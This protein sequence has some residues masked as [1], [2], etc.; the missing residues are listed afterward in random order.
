MARAHVPL[1]HRLLTGVVALSLSSPALV[2]LPGTALTSVTLLPSD[3]ARTSESVPAGNYGNDIALRVRSAAG[4]S[5]RSY[6]KFSVTGLSGS[7]ASA[8]L[9][10]YVTDATPDGGRVYPTAT[11]WSESSITWSSAPAISGPSLGAVGPAALSA[12][13][14][15]DVTSTI[16]GNGAYSF[17]VSDGA[18]NSVLFSSSEGANPPQLVITDGGVPAPP[19]SDFIASPTSGAAPLP[20][21]FTDASTGQPTSWAWDFDGDGITDSTLQHPQHLYQAPG[22]YSV[23]LTVQNDLGTDTATKDELISVNSAT[24]IVGAGDIARCNAGGDEQ[25][26]ALLGGI[27]GTVITLGDNAYE[28][29]SAAEYANCYDPTWGTQKGRT[30]PAPGNHEYQTPGATGYFGYFGATAGDPSRGYYGYDLGSWHVIVLNSE[31]AYIGGCGAG[32]PEEQWLRADLAEHASANV[33]AI[34][35]KPRFSSGT[36]H[37]SDP[38]MGPF[39]NALYEYGADIILNGHEHNYERFAPQS[40]FGVSDATYGIRELVSGTGGASHY[41]FGSPI[42]NSE[43]RNNTTFGVLKLT[44]DAASYSW[45]FVPVGGGS[46]TDSGTTTTHGPPPPSHTVTVAPTDDAYV[47]EAAPTTNYSSDTTLRLR[48]RRGVSAHSYLSF[49]VSGVTAAPTSARLRLYCTDGSP[50]GGS[51]YLVGGPWSESTITWANAPPIAGTRLGAFGPATVGT[52]VELDLTST[53][54]GDGTYT[55]GITTTTNN[56]TFYTSS[57]GTAPPQ[58]V[59]TVPD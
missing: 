52:W 45:E 23:A 46:F 28:N 2:V 54:T 26:A 17:V 9:R 16:T 3:D 33:L 20:V 35:H 59:V 7:A 37:G 38:T 40:P 19:T 1:R 5:Y 18:D 11:T 21:T 6:L 42:A 24:V 31:C 36:T 49:T 34:W 57:E 50:D 53:V 29:G 10:L 25:T 32:S 8:R 39:W 58:L 15:V 47:N 51:L 44:L 4:G 56:A 48:Q 43:V 13:V 41:P 30:L 14:E 27:G 22:T 55:F 12:W